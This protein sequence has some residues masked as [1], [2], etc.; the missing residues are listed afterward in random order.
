MSNHVAVNTCA[1][2]RWF[3]AQADPAGNSAGGCFRYPPIPLVM[4]HMNKI[5]RQPEQQIVMQYAMVMPG[6]TACGEFA[7]KANVLAAKDN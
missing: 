7:T 3:R 2:C 1:G 4:T 5:S 6:A